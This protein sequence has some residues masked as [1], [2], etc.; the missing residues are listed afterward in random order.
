MPRLLTCQFRF[1]VEKDWR[2]AEL[3]FSGGVGGATVTYPG[4][5]RPH[6]S[7]YYLPWN[8]PRSFGIFVVN[9][10]YPRIDGAFQRGCLCESHD[11]DIYSESLF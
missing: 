10:Q 7:T 8:V 1:V 5:K 6:K 11:L 2:G 4:Y 9:V 3:S